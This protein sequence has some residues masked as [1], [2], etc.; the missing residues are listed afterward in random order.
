M[1]TI[2]TDTA[3]GATTAKASK[4]KATAAPVNTATDISWFD[5]PL[6]TWAVATMG[7][8]PTPAMFKAALVLGKPGVGKRPGH[9]ALH[10][11]MCLRREGC[12]VRQFCT[13]GSCGPAN[14]WRRALRRDYGLVSEAKT[15]T[16]YAFHLMLTAK[17]RDMLKAAGVAVGE[18]TLDPAIKPAKA[19]KAISAA[20]KPAAAPVDAAPVNEPA[21]VDA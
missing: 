7:A 10:I 12:T 19:P 15:G 5:G 3:K 4:A 13:A 21:K 17:G 18:L 11:A 1:T 14:N 20:P 9:E 6:A 16:P 8:K 2:H